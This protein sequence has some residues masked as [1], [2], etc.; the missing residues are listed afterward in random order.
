MSKLGRYSANR[1]KIEEL[2]STKTVEVHDCGTIFTLDSATEF[3]VT[4]PD[5]S[6]SGPGWWAEFHILGAPASANYTVVTNSENVLMGKVFASHTTI[7]GSA[8]IGNHIIEGNTV[9]FVDALAVPG[10]HVRIIGTGTHYIATAYASA[11]TGIT[12]TAE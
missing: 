2:T 4:L 8:T 6:S 5:V 12:I 3:A 11:S 7:D 10:D 1:Y 9:T